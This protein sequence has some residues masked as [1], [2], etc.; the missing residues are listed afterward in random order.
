MPLPENYN[1]ERS[2]YLDQYL[3]NLEKAKEEFSQRWINKYN[4]DFP[5]SENSLPIDTNINEQ[6]IISEIKTPINDINYFRDLLHGYLYELSKNNDI[7]EYILDNLDEPSIIYLA[8]NWKSVRST[9]KKTIVPPISKEDF[10]I[11]LLTMIKGNKDIQ[12]SIEADTKTRDMITKPPAR[13]L[14]KD[15]QLFLTSLKIKELKEFIESTDL[16]MRTNNRTKD[17]LKN[18]IYTRI[19]DK[20]S[21]EEIEDILLSN[22]PS[23]LSLTPVK[24]MG[25][26]VDSKHRVVFNHK[27]A[28]DTKLLSKNLLSLKYSSTGN[29]HQKFRKTLITDN[30]K[31]FVKNLIENNKPNNE[32]FEKLD[33]KEKRLMNRLCEYLDLD[34][35]LS[36]DDDFQKNFNIL[37]GSYLA[38]NDSIYVKNQLKKYILTGIQENSIPKHTGYNMLLELAMT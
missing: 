16:K 9:I 28:I 36:Y 7:V 13:D 25:K 26:G 3:K 33:F 23:R 5:Y 14:S 15:L 20:Y 24:K 11:K 27:Y 32:L 10:L 38:G 34:G 4:A 22:R 29:P 21:A 37:Y 35:E 2:K 19:L 8:N 12:N 1:N 17:E 30:G 18:E 6:P 31:D